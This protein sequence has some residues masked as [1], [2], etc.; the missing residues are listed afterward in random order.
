MTVN[1]RSVRVKVICIYYIIL[2]LGENFMVNIQNFNKTYS[3]KFFKF[4]ITN[5]KFIALLCMIASHMGLVLAYPGPE[6]I[7]ISDGFD[8]FLIFIGKIALPLFAFSIANGWVHTKN[9]MNYFMRMILFA[10]IS[11][12]PYTMTFYITNLHPPTRNNNF[13]L[14]NL[15]PVWFLAAVL[16]VVFIFSRYFVGFS[17]KNSILISFSILISSIFLDIN[18]FRYLCDKPNIFYPFIVSL[19]L[20]Y[21]FDKIRDKSQKWYEQVFTIL[22]LVL[23]FAFVGS[24]SDFIA[25]TFTVGLVFLLYLTYNHRWLQSVIIAL[26]GILLYGFMFHNIYNMFSAC[27]PV[28]ISAIII[29]FYDEI[30]KPKKQ[31]GFIG[32]ILPIY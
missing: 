18:G 15:T 26:W 6:S 17:L 8:D 5:I 13:T 25:S 11:Q 7:R 10:C 12:I 22:T 16:L 31:D 32:P 28:I 2:I 30:M 29:L 9:K 27:L 3:K 23:S 1:I 20:I 21:C 19:F 24:G 4:S 14:Y